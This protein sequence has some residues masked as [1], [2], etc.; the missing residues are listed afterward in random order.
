MAYV[1]QTS[2]RDVSHM[3]NAIEYVAR[4]EK[5]LTISDF[6]SELQ[7]SLN[8]ISSV[9]TSHG[10]H[11]TYI[12]CSGHNTFKEFEI[13]RKLHDKDKGVIAHHYYQSF[14]KDDDVNPELAHKIGV[15]LARKIF[16]DFQV[17]VTTHIDREH[18]HNHIIV[19]SCNIQTG[20]KWY[21]NKTSLN[22]IRVESDKLCLRNGLSI[23]EKNSKYK[24]LDKTTY[25]LGMKNKS[26]KIWLVRDLDEAVLKCKSKDEFIKFLT[27]RDYT[28][29]YKDLHITITKIGEKK[30][31]RV[32]TLAKQFGDKYK[33]ENLEKLM[34]YYVPTTESETV[35][36]AVKEE[37]IRQEQ[38]TNWEHYERRIFRKRKYL[39]STMNNIRYD[40]NA[41]RIIRAARSVGRS[42]STI[43][44]IIKA[45]FLISCIK[46]RSTDYRK[47][48]YRCNRKTT[49]LN[50]EHYSCIGSIDYNRL[51]NSS[52]ENFT[53]KVDSSYLLRVANQPIFYSALIS[54]QDGL[55]EITV[56]AKDKLFLLK[57]LQIEYMQ[58]EFTEQDEKISNQRMYKSLKQSAESREIKMQYLSVSEHELEILKKNYINI[59]YFKNDGEKYNI[60]FLPESYGVIKKLLNVKVK[61]TETE[62]QRNMKIY[63]ELKVEASRIGEKLAYKAN[64]TSDQIEYMKSENIR[65][66]YFH[67]KND[68]TLYDIAY[69]KQD[70]NII[71]EIVYNNKKTGGLDGKK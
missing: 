35:Q 33:K 8:H 9:D 62:V 57:L 17:V 49:Y 52:G 40:K 53:I 31:I 50:P 59:A 2:I 39:K 45:L 16:Q 34:G 30:G 28:V 1:G 4:E 26:W 54:R 3:S 7:S 25:Q 5:A 11:A 70:E 19:N 64:I 20:Q 15:E 32:D 68:K 13:M 56:K 14:R 21:S 65:F 18:I 24:T 41:G 58:H 10:E 47:K 60:A 46:N 61:S 67:N 6:R 48:R 22:S 55:A 66:A 27:E 38:L 44:M 63:N 51:V 43:E 23:I 29:R 37:K 42:R 36:F 69:Q 71:R 12:N